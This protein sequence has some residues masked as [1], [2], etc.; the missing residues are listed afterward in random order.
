MNVEVAALILTGL[1]VFEDLLKMSKEPI[2]DKNG[3]V[4]A[5]NLEE[6]RLMPSADIFK[7]V[8][9]KTKEEVAIP[10]EDETI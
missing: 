5:N 2:I 8:F 7:E 4:I 6:Y 10:K 3:D 1:R 9:G